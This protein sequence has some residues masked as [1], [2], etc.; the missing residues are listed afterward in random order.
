MNWSRFS[1]L[2][3]SQSCFG[4][5]AS[6]IHIEGPRRDEGDGWN[7]RN[8]WKFKEGDVPFVL[9]QELLSSYEHY[10]H[11]RELFPMWKN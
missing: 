1:L 5:T 11:G 7:S 4:G 8:I 2:N 3:R 9:T 6:S 10:Q